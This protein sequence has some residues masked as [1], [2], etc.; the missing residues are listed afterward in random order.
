MTAPISIQKKTNKTGL[1]DVSF[2]LPLYMEEY[3]TFMQ[4]MHGGNIVIK[5]N[6]NLPY[7]F[8]GTHGTLYTAIKS[9]HE[10]VGNAETKNRHIVV[11]HGASQ[12]VS[13]IAYAAGKM[14][15]KDIL[16]EPPYWGRLK[17]L[18]E[19]GIAASG[20]S[21]NNGGHVKPGKSLMGD[22]WFKFATSP[23]NPD[24]KIAAPDGDLQVMDMCYSWPQY[25]KVLKESYDVMIFGLS[26]ATGHAGTRIGWAIVKDHN[27]ADLMREY[28]H[29]ST[30][31]VSTDAQLRAA[32]VI[33]SAMSAKKLEMPDCF[34]FGK[35]KLQKRWRE[36]NAAIS[37]T[38]VVVTNNS[39]MFAW[40]TC[41][42]DVEGKYGLKATPGSGFG[43]ANSSPYFR[44][45]LGCGDI[46]FAA[47]IK[48]LSGSKTPGT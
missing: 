8:G 19:M 20:V 27:V 7:T 47:M 9:L 10:Y 13:A 21:C 46:E 28:V 6:E 41:E 16:L 1:I 40:C 32:M 31:G 22:S 5:N 34:A 15:V 14:H 42:D 30:C 36:F 29:M 23:N 48:A 39:G 26:K 35:D 44:I 37:K 4:R 2:G 33:N 38:N 18:L 24:G 12:V 3:W 43:L 25:T 45:N 11:G 17:F